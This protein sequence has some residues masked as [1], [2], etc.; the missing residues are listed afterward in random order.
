MSMME[1]VQWLDRRF[2]FDHT[3]NIFPAALERL[4]KMPLQLFQKINEIPTDY[5]SIRIGNRWSIKENIGH[6]TDLE[7]LGWLRLDEILLGREEMQPADPSNRKTEEADH[8]SR[9]SSYLLEEFAASRNQTLLLLENLGERDLFR[10]SRH[11]RLK[12]PMRIMDLS[13]FIAE[14]DD[15]H[16]DWIVFLE[17]QLRSSH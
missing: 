3:E 14:H 6:L 17:N 15:H 11:P 12:T 9:S 1:S 10:S 7:P 2:D 13:L 4:R 16:F 8:N 5:L